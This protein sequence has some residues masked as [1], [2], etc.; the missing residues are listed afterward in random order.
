VS[1]P[2]HRLA[3]LATALAALTLAACGGGY[4]AGAPTSTL[5][6]AAV[7]SAAKRLATAPA[8]LRANAADANTI[9]GTGTAAL[10]ARLAKL[11]GQPVVVNQWASWCGPC[12]AEFPLFADAV[13]VHGSKVAFLGIDFNDNRDDARRFLD[14][15]P[16]GF[17]SIY[18]RSGDAVRSLGGRSIAPTTFFI[19]S[20][21]KRRYIKFGGYS[22]AATLEADVR[23]YAR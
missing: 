9:A 3:A 15:L 19:G 4:G 1:R 23:R 22:D 8:A 7:Q 5:S 20:D 13:A 16:P 10:D 18:D 11:K 12:R 21:G 14:E 17:A 6:A 2:A